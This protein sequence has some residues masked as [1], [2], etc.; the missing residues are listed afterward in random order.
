MMRISLRVI[1]AVELHEI[2]GIVAHDADSTL[3][4]FNRQIA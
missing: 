1:L 4:D 3:C 2:G